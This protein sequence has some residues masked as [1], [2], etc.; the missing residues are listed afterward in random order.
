MVFL[1]SCSLTMVSFYMR[2]HVFTTR[3]TCRDFEDSQCGRRG[4]GLPTEPKWLE[5]T[6]RL[7]NVSKLPDAFGPLTRQVLQ[8]RPR[9]SELD[10]FCGL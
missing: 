2:V 3:T 5:G 4:Q 1:V 7:T 8:L 9:R 10:D 6:W